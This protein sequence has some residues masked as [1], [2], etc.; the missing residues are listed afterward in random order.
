[1]T[2]GMSWLDL[3]LSAPIV[4]IACEP[5]L[6]FPHEMADALRKTIEG[7]QKRFPN[8]LFF[9]PGQ[10]ALINIKVGDGFQ[11]DILGNALTATFKYEQKVVDVPAALPRLDSPAVRPFSELLEE[12]VAYMAATCDALTAPP[13]ELTRVGV[14]ADCR[15]E[16]EGLPPGITRLLEHVGQPWGAPPTL[17]NGVF[18]NELG[19]DDDWTYRCHHTLDVN[20]ADRPGDVRL[21]LDWQMVRNP[22]RKLVLHRGAAK[23]LL[24]GAAEQAKTYFEAFAAGNLDY[25]D[26]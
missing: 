11:V 26:H 1:M 9:I 23:S 21:R 2:K 3:A 13:I 15:L 4:G 17:F 12:G 8:I 16:E 18:L 14:V 10:G 25:A 22:A 5:R 19:R 6:Q 20:T 24:A 7:W